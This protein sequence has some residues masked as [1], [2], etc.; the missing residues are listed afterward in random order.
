MIKNVHAAQYGNNLLEKVIGEK[1]LEFNTD[2]SCFMLMG[3]KSARKKLQKQLQQTPLALCEQPM[4]EVKVLKYLGEFL[5]VDLA[6]SV[7]QTVIK[8][9]SIV[10]QT[11]YEIR[12]V[13]EDTRAEHLG[14]L[15]IAF[16]I[17][18]QAILSMLTF[19]SG[20]WVSIPRKTFRV[21]DELFHM[22]C[23]IILRVS[24][25]CPIPSYYWQSGFLKFKNIILE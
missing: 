23:R 20:T 21:L 18:K 24:S 10:K 19:N 9:A 25:G 1:S 13:I 6:E 2:K 22:F 5:S 12:A 17:W 3:N 4:K 15:N 7:H 16:M 8:R 11:I 14:A